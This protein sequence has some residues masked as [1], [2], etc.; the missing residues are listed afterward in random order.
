MNAVTKRFFL[1]A[2][3]TVFSFVG[4]AQLSKTDVEAACAKITATSHS[5]FNL[6]VNNNVDKHLME[7]DF[8]LEFKENTLVIHNG[9]N[10]IHVAYKGIKYVS[11]GKPDKASGEVKGQW[12]IVF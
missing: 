12:Y 4:N 10:E 5:H 7:A 8:K 11:V 2:L 1:A 3:F 6:V 9:L